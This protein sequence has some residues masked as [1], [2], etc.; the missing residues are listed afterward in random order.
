MSSMTLWQGDCAGFCIGWGGGWARRSF[1]SLTTPR[2][3]ES[4]ILTWGALCIENRHQKNLAGVRCQLRARGGLMA[5]MT[6]G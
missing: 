5:F 1:R 2:L 4:V 6:I 3:D